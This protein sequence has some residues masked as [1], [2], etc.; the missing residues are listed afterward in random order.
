[1]ASMKRMRSPSCDRLSELDS[2]SELHMAPTAEQLGS[3]MK[4]NPAT[5]CQT[6]VSM[7]LQ[8]SPK[9]KEI[10]ADAL[11]SMICTQSSLAREVVA[12][13]AIP[14][15]TS[16]LRESD[17]ALNEVASHAL[18]SIAREKEF[19]GSV[20]AAGAIPL[21]VAVATRHT[22]A[23]IQI[24]AAIDALG[25]VAQNKDYTKVVEAGILPVLGRLLQAGSDPVKGSAAYTLSVITQHKAQIGAVV[26]AQILPVIV[27]MLVQR[28]SL[29]NRTCTAPIAKTSW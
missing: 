3:C 25:G 11:S 28:L 18:C 7:L 26:S 9:Q 2:Q 19:T 21:L 29:R 23:E 4:P 20:V 16:M 22:A 17:A 14:V 12:A 24:E 27:T 1:M 6:Y 10:A 13:G 15:L 8:G 5:S